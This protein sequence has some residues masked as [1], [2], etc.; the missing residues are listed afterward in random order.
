MRAWSAVRVV[1]EPAPSEPL[2]R[3]KTRSLSSARPCRTRGSTRGPTPSLSILDS[4]TRRSRPWPRIW[5]ILSRRGFVTPQPQKRPKSSFIRFEAEQPNE[6]W[7][8]DLTHWALAD[9]TPLSILNILDDHSRLLVGSDARTATKAADVVA[10][11]HKAAAS[12][13][14]PASVLTDNGVHRGVPR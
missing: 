3:S 5:R 1:P 11:F 12:H 2:R 9:R 13:G 10:S 14:F 8:A 7:Q 6:R 4:A